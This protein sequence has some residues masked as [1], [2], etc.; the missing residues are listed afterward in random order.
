[1]NGTRTAVIL[2][3]LALVAGASGLGY[4]VSERI[5]RA[6]PPASAPS[7]DLAGT[8]APEATVTPP[9]APASLSP[10]S[11]PAPPPAAVRSRETARVPVSLTIES[12]PASVTSG[13]PIVIHW[14]VHGPVAARKISTRLATHFEGGVHIQSSQVSSSKLP[15]R[16]EATVT[17][18]GSGTLTV[19]AHVTVNG[20]PLRAEQTLRVE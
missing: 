19:A 2:I 15:A 7:L 18:V 20:Q 8:P 10:L 13:T 17:P 11:S 5:E 3:G 14:Q 16:F 12:V 1:M 4:W 6:S 9:A